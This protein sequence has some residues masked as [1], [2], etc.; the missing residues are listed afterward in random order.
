M[1][2]Y[3]HIVYPAG[4]V[5]SEAIGNWAEVC[6]YYYNNIHQQQQQHHEYLTFNSQLAGVIMF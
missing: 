6:N 5:S 4:L 3:P 1:Q 2:K